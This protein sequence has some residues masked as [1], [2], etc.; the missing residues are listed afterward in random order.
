MLFPNLE[1]GYI[2]HNE[3]IIMQMI[4]RHTPTIIA[5]NYEFR[6][7][8]EY[9]Q[10][11]KSY[12]SL[13]DG[14][15]DLLRTVNTDGIIINC[16]KSYAKNFGY[17]KEEVIGK[18]IFD[19]VVT[20]EKKAMRNSFETWKKFGHVRNKLIWFKRKNG[21][22]FPGLVSANNLYDEHGKL[23]GSNTVIRDVSEIF[24]SWKKINESKNRAH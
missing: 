4:E 12:Q 10:T 15:P 20:R 3:L 16:N 22:T 8:Q 19:H 17:T 9:L 6:K 1:M 2:D 23:I 14:S 13:Y 11:I 21:I 24:N 5:K 7:T 18:S